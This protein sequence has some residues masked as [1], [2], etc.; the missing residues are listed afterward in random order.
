MRILVTGGA[1]FIGSK[2]CKKLIEDNH[3][4]TIL[5]SLDE[6]IHKVQPITY[7][8]IIIDDIRNKQIVSKLIKNTD[9]IY[10]LAA[11]TGTGQS[12]YE[13]EKYVDINVNGTA[14]LLECLL[15]EKHNV[16]TII[17]TSSRAVY[18]EG[19]YSCP[20]HGKL[21]GKIKRYEIDMKNKE[22]DIKC[23]ICNKNCQSV[24]TKETD[25]INPISTYAL[26]KKMQ[27]DLF[28]L[29]KGILNINIIITRLQN[30]YG[31]GQALNNPY[32]GI[33]SIFS[34]RILNNKNIDIF[35]DGVES[36]D[37]IHVNDVV[38]YLI[39]C[40]S[41]DGGIYNI[42]SGKYLTVNKV[43]KLLESNYKLQSNSRITNN[44]RI[45]DIRHCCADMSN[46]NKTFGEIDKLSI[47]EGL[48]DF[49]QWVLQQKNYNI[50]YEESLTELKKYNLFK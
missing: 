44:F 43:V 5:D 38:K 32:T 30:V 3:E 25:D 9:I 10:H 36:R 26:T 40:M 35:E 15:K 39:K 34:S 24:P 33:L 31:S 17:L 22:Y 27:E 20:A 7:G 42:G 46:T 13:I 4:V 28:L 45:G 6:Q 49:C 18:G 11:Q 29:Y 14:I 2:L 47:E 23:S 21:S 1:G 16:K 41:V 12:V 48:Y 37:F 50:N 19:S 8:S